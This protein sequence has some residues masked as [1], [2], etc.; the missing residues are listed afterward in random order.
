MRLFATRQIAPPAQQ[1]ESP[2]PPAQVP[3]SL[4]V[5]L[6]FPETQPAVMPYV[7]TTFDL[8]LWPG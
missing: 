8:P 2:E 5:P 7:P 3:D 6:A 1:P 4:P